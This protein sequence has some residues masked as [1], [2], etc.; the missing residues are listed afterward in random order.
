MKLNVNF[1]KKK[2]I[3]SSIIFFILF[4]IG[5]TTSYNYALSIGTTDVPGGHSFMEDPTFFKILR[6]NITVCTIGYLGIL[7]FGI[8]SIIVLGYNGFLLGI[9]LGV[10]FAVTGQYWYYIKILIPHTIFELPAIILSCSTGLEGF[11]FF[12]KYNLK[13]II[14]DILIILILLIIAAFI[15]VNISKAL[16]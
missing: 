12:K 16:S 2:I 9:I 7:C 6:N 4:I 1:N 10:S 14:T 5:L 3:T 13:S 8:S 11:K 15:E